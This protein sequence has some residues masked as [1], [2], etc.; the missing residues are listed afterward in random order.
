MH[1]GNHICGGS[2]INPTT[3]VTAAHCIILP[4]ISLTIRAGSSN[5]LN[6]GQ[7][8]PITISFIHPLYNSITR[9]NDIAIM[10][11][12]QPLVFGSGVQPI[13]IPSQGSSEGLV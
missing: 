10:K 11:L 7:V 6:G 13:N 2:I 3:I 9:E 4:I 8:I 5:R 12:V 1:Y